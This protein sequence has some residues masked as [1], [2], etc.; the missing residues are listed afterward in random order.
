MTN[1]HERTLP[2]RRES[3][4]QPPDHQSDAH[5]TEQLRPASSGV[6]FDR[7][8]CAS[9]HSKG[10][11]LGRVSVRQKCE[12]TTYCAESPKNILINSISHFSPLCALLKLHAK[13]FR[14]M[15]QP[16]VN[17]NHSCFKLDKLLLSKLRTNSADHR[18]LVYFLFFPE[19]RS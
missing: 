1:L 17:M 5:P 18:L 6:I 16:P 14:V 3:N 4:P 10:I 2:T 9:M 19:N 8:V 13:N 11:G 7:Y 15:P 12:F